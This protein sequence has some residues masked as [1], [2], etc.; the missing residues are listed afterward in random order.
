MG[1]ALFNSEIR[2]RCHLSFFGSPCWDWPNSERTRSQGICGGKRDRQGLLEYYHRRH[3]NAMKPKRKKSPREIINSYS[4]LRDQ[5][6]HT[7]LLSRLSHKEHR[8]CEAAR[9]LPSG[10]SPPWEEEERVE[11]TPSVTLSSLIVAWWRCFACEQKSSEVRCQRIMREF[12]VAS[13]SCLEADRS[14][15]ALVL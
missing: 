1:I 15:V 10:N 4:T 7:C 13:G 5:A 11:A 3:L 14:A 8:A 12:L 2:R 9:C 6:G